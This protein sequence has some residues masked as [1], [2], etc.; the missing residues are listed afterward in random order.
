MTKKISN[1]KTK[2]TTSTSKEKVKPRKRS[3]KV[4]FADKRNTRT[5]NIVNEPTR[6]KNQVVV[7]EVTVTKELSKK[8]FTAL[9]AKIQ[10]EQNELV[11]FGKKLLKSQKDLD[12]DI[13][14]ALDEQFMD[15]I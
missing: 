7:K 11:N 13:A 2:K 15:L 10:A 9:S 1:S 3:S 5:N 8:E 4:F 12:P 14:K 6:A